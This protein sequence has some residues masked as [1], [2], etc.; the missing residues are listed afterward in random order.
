MREEGI[1][2]REEGCGKSEEG[3]GTGMTEEGK[4]GEKASGNKSNGRGKGKEREVKSDVGVV[5]FSTRRQKATNRVYSKFV[6]H[7]KIVY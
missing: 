4:R 1:G 6:P 7:Q 5:R 3:E 2:K